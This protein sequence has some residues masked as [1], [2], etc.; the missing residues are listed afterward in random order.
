MKVSD[1]LARQP[2]ECAVAD[3]DLSIEALARIFLSH[4]ALR[5]L[6]IVSPERLILGRIRHHR[7]AKL[8]LSEHLPV[9]T[10]HQIMERVFGGTAGEI[11]ER[12]FVSAHPDE[13]LDNVLHRMLE[14][15]VDDMPV[16]DDE[17]HIIGT[18]NLTDIMRASLNNGL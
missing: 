11:M 14:Y 3:V 13:E 4:P 1:W 12:D 15:M 6:Y 8:L 16:I 10:S 2:R 9:Q 17:K 5:D 18:I 7:L